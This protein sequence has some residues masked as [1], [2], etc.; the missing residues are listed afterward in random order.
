VIPKVQADALSQALL[1]ST[2]DNQ[3]KLLDAIHK[4][5]GG[6]AAYM[7]TLKKIAVNALCGGCRRPDG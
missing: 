2:P 4:G 1:Q 5:T 7:A 6:G 3:S